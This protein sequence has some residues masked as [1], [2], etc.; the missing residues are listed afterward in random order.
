MCR[1]ER[2]QIERA[3]SQAKR[4]DKRTAD[5][6]AAKAERAPG[7][8]PARRPLQRKKPLAGRVVAREPPSPDPALVR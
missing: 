3:D 4:A 7:G 2:R 8:K 6:E 1:A 5:G